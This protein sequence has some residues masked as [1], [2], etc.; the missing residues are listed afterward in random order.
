MQ[1]TARETG[2]G[3]TLVELLVV[4]V[5]LGFVLT[6]VMPAFSGSVTTLKA[7]EASRQVVR[8]LQLARTDA[9][10]LGKPVNVIVDF[11]RQRIA[12]S[13]GVI[14]HPPQEMHLAAEQAGSE[15]LSLGF[16]PDGSASSGS[17]YLGAPGRRYHYV[18][19]PMTGRVHRETVSDPAS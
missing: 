7:R 8:L 14:F 17:F 1:G 16:H 19:E 10:T 6:L 5:L 4:I 11:E 18:I 15:Q 13:V 12:P 9:I 3:F 2:K